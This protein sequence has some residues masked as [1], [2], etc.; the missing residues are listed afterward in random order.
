MVMIR[1]GAV[2][3]VVPLLHYERCLIDDLKHLYDQISA[4]SDSDSE[5]RAFS[6]N[7]FWKW[8]WPNYIKKCLSDDLSGE[9]VHEYYRGSRN[10][11]YNAC[12]HFIAHVGT[13]QNNLSRVEML[14]RVNE[15]F[16]ARLGDQAI[17]KVHFRPAEEDIE[18]WSVIADIDQTFSPTWYHHD[19]L[20]RRTSGQFEILE[21][22]CKCALSWEF[23]DN[24][25]TIDRL[26]VQ[27]SDFEAEFDVERED[28][29]EE[30]LQYIGSL[31]GQLPPVKGIRRRPRSSVQ[32]VVS[33]PQNRC[34]VSNNTVA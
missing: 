16:V 18:R 24:A 21:W 25:E 33:A 2:E 12:L 3:F 26:L 15:G 17:E 30:D 32:P 13:E 7:A 4:D 27:H 23:P 1:K 14:R 5:T 28:Y 29:T 19:F 6:H 22:A 9:S 8:N 11:A 34:P 31:D 10:E 20:Q